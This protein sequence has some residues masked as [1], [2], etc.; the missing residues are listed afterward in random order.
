MLIKVVF[1][2]MVLNQSILVL[3]GCC[4]GLYPI[5]NF[6][7]DFCRWFNEGD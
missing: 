7:P 4:T 3:P 1:I 6:V 2:L 5:S